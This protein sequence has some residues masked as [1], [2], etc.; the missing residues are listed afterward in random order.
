[1]NDYFIKGFEKT[2]N[3]GEL[4]EVRDA[5]KNA[6]K[7]VAAG[8]GAPLGQMGAAIMSM[9]PAMS[10]AMPEKYIPLAM[11]LGGAL[12]SASASEIVRG[13]EEYS[14]E[15][16]KPAAGAAIGAGLGLL[17]GKKIKALK[18]LD[19]AAMFAGGGLGGMLGDLT[20]ND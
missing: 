13:N 9:G 6:M 18:H 3:E 8:L 4:I 5:L 19:V 15:S 1:M 2:A 11:G 12:G 16:L 7:P 20:R 17:L 10:G 14:K